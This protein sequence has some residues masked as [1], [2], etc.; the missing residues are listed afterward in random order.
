MGYME[1]PDVCGMIEH[2]FQKT[3]YPADKLDIEMVI[4][5]NPLSGR[6]KLNLTPAQVEQMTA[7]NDTIPEMIKALEN[8]VQSSLSGEP[9]GKTKKQ[10]LN[11][12]A[13]IR[14]VSADKSGP[15]A[16]SSIRVR[17]TSISF[18]V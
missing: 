12:G 13:S 6:P 4:N 8:K 16:K 1:G 5:G 18:D 10:R 14:E 15:T 17:E 3:L 11:R 7:E 9:V 2:Y